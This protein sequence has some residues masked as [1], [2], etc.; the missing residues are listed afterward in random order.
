MAVRVKAPKMRHLHDKI[1][2]FRKHNFITKFI[3]NVIN[4]NSYKW[5]IF[6]YINL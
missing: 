1:I 4:F 2:V 5:K 3:K 6:F